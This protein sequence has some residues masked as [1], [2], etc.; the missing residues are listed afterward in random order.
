MEIQEIQ[1][2]LHTEQNG[3]SILIFAFD[4]KVSLNIWVLNEGFVFRKVDAPSEAIF[5]L[6]VELLGMVNVNV[7]RNSSFQ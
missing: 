5:R 4:Y 3:T 7:D 6:M 1:Q 2:T